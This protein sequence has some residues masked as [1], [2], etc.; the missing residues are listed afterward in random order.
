MSNFNYL[1]Y[2]LEWICWKS[3]NYLLLSKD[4]TLNWGELGFQLYTSTHDVHHQIQMCAHERREIRRMKK[5]EIKKKRPNEA[6]FG[7]IE[8]LRK[9][10]EK[11]S[12]PKTIY[13]HIY[14]S[15]RDIWHVVPTFIYYKFGWFPKPNIAM[16]WRQEN[17]IQLELWW[18]F[19]VILLVRLTFWWFCCDVFIFIRNFQR[20]TARTICIQIQISCILQLLNGNMLTS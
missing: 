12:L 10:V 4:W 16:H 6:K 19:A 7:F 5:N 11:I 3:S 9:C 18:T 2:F 20:K 1:I 13:K 15:N 17:N 8:R 14:T